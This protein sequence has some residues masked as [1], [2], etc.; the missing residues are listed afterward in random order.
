MRIHGNPAV[1]S[2]LR[3]AESEVINVLDGTGKHKAEV[4]K[5]FAKQSDSKLEEKGESGFPRQK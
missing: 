2:L 1:K 3:A 5:L 4:K